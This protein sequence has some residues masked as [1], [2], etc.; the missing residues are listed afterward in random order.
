[1][2]PILFK[3]IRS[4]FSN[5]IPKLIKYGLN[6]NARDRQGECILSRAIE[7]CGEHKAYSPYTGWSNINSNFLEAR[8]NQDLVEMLIDNGAYINDR[9]LLGRTLLMEATMWKDYSLVRLLISKGAN[10]DLQDDRGMTALMIAVTKK[11]L[12]RGKLIEFLLVHDVNINMQDNNG[13][14][15]L[16]HLVNCDCSKDNDLIDAIQLLL[17]YGADI[18]IKNNNGESALDVAN[19]NN[20]IGAS[21]FL[22]DYN[23]KDFDFKNTASIKL[24]LLK[25]LRELFQQNDDLFSLL[26]KIEKLLNSKECIVLK[27]DL[28]NYAKYYLKKRCAAEFINFSKEELNANL[29]VILEINYTDH[30]EVEVAKLI[31]AGANPNLMVNHAKKEWLVKKLLT[32]DFLDFYARNNKDQSARDLALNCDS[33]ILTL[34]DNAIENNDQ[35]KKEEW[36]NSYLNPSSYKVYK[37]LFDK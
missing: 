12:D 2:S 14:T 30:V 9:G 35:K 16:I 22:R 20:N 11:S 4:D 24:E 25:K 1:M 26:D 28:L 19:I 27:D 32:F 15:A 10:I 36:N 21:N 8:H 29:K 33:N 34:I 13:N 23:K 31:I 6:I 37:K 3:I 7:K 17:G 18:N 5:L